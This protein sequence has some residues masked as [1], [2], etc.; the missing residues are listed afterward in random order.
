MGTNY[1]QILGM[2]TNYE[3]IPG[4]LGTN[5]VGIPGMGAN[6]VEIP[7]LGTNCVC[8]VYLAISLAATVSFEQYSGNAVPINEDRISAR[9]T[10]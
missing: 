7:G 6:Y 8:T 3:E 4:G 10:R 2:G 9:N 1:V 5:Y